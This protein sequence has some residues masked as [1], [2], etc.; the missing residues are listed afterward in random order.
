VVIASV[1]ALVGAVLLGFVAG[2]WTLKRSQQWCKACGSTLT[3]PDCQRA[4][5]HSLNVPGS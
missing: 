4:G 1:G 3:C 5:L 2:L